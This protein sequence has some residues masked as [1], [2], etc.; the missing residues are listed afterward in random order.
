MDA[1]AGILVVKPRTGDN[2][3]VVADKDTKVV[4]DRKTATLADV[5]IGMGVFIAPATGT[6][7]TISAVP[8]SLVAA[9]VPN[10]TVQGNKTGVLPQNPL[11]QELR[12][13]ASQGVTY[14]PPNPPTAI[15]EADV[16]AKIKGWQDSNG[17]PPP[18][19]SG[20]YGPGLSVFLLERRNNAF[21]ASSGIPGAD[22]K[23]STK[24]LLVQTQESRP[25]Q[26]QSIH[27]CHSFG[28]G[29]DSSCSC[30]REAGPRGTRQDYNESRFQLRG[31]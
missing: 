4:V 11:V 7:E 21:V 20:M 18:Q 12:K 27:V 23:I 22:G 5:K 2:L 6:A 24:G 10:P 16:T 13:Q 1:G 14:F 19:A 9:G 29:M 26:W 3:T 8:G 30:Y 31:F 28:C 15:D 25:L 17:Q